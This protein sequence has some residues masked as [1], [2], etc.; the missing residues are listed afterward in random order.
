MSGSR[1]LSNF[2]RHLLPA[3][4]AIL[5]LTT[6]NPSI[7]LGENP[8][9]D[10]ETAPSSTVSALCSP[11]LVAVEAGERFVVSVP[12]LNLRSGPNVVCDIVAELSR[13]TA[14]VQIGDEKS[15]DDYTWVPVKTD[16]GTG[17]VIRESIQS[18]LDGTSC[19]SAGSFSETGE[20]GFTADVVNLRSGPGLGCS[21]VTELNGG[22]PVTVMG[23]VVEQDGESW[24]PVSTPLGDGYIYLDGYAP[25]GTW[26]QPVAVAVLMYHDV[27]DYID[28]YRV[29]PWQLE[30]QLIWLRDNGYSSITPR[31]LIAN[32]DYGAPLPPRPVILSVDDGWASV[33]VFRDL[34]AAYGFKGTYFLPNYAE[35]APE[36][37]WELNQYGEVCGHTVS[38]LFLDQLSYEGQAYEIG[39]NK[40]WL[41]SIL[42]T[43]TTCFAYPFG[44]YSDVTTEVVASSGYQI[45]FDAWNGVQYF[46]G[47]LNRWHVNRVEVS[48]F[49]DLATF[50]AAVAY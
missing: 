28:R 14:L 7:A 4:L 15:D 50:V 41:D 42:G 18:T 33:R 22:T 39:G 6:M 48:G 16:A 24:I 12:E 21:I 26:V 36:E 19:G 43:S 29:A 49:F 45:A 2:H 9:G 38:H 27:G 13:D 1:F 32:I 8:S 25:P 31:D 34:L 35:L 30:E 44:S 46:D 17:Y 20:T 40:A 23:S 37:I 11:N 47:S 3:A 10:K 5:L